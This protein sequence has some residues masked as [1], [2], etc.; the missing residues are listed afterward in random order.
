MVMKAKWL[1]LENAV[2]W[3]NLDTHEVSEHHRRIGALGRKLS[4]ERRLAFPGSENWETKEK[5][6]WGCRTETP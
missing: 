6:G 2:V 1:A 4:V 3:V 5:A